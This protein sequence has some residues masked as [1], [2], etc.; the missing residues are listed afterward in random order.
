MSEM[1]AGGSSVASGGG[2]GGATGREG[3]LEWR[4]SRWRPMVLSEMDA[5]ES[6][7]AGGGGA[8]DGEGALEWRR[9]KRQ[10]MVPSEMDSRGSNDVAIFVKPL[11]NQGYTVG[12]YFSKPGPS[13]FTNQRCKLSRLV[14]SVH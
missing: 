5:G 3:T 2:E 1:D 14:A 9:W 11:H 8:A 7:A 6:S 10:P 4:R 12:V 13:D